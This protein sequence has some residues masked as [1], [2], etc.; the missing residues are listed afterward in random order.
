MD[1]LKAHK[2]STD[3]RESI[4]ES[5]NCGC[6]C[7]LRIFPSSEIKEWWDIDEKGIGQTAV[8]PH[9]G[10]DAILGDKDLIVNDKFLKKM[11]KHW[12]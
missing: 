12:F 9:C 3:H 4:L 6:F 10:I 1:I 2:F 7:C 11:N 5:E 8:C